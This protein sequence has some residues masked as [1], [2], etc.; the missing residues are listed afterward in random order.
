[1]FTLFGNCQDGDA[2][3]GRRC[4]VWHGIDRAQ[5]RFCQLGFG[6]LLNMRGDDACFD[7]LTHDMVVLGVPQLASVA[8]RYFLHQLS[9]IY[10]SLRM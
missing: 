2:A 1:V 5:C 3:P 9:F 7:A 6:T 4:A 8:Y 10:E